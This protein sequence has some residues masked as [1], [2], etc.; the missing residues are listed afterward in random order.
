MWES[1]N[2]LTVDEPLRLLWDRA[3]PLV[4]LHTAGRIG[5]AVRAAL[6]LTGRP[7]VVS[8]HGPLLTAQTWQ[9]AALAERF[10]GVVDLGRPFGL[11]VGARR[12][13]DDAARLIT[14]NEEERVAMTARYGE[15]VIRMDQGVDAER[16]EAG[17]R[18][19]HV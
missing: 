5:G 8:I 19:R 16:L 4:H 11:L 10:S 3:L 15:R 13:L 17:D 18:K 14:F 1:G 9:K 2:V 12:V 6:R 7:Y